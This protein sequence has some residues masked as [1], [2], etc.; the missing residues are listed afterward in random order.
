MR[1]IFIPLTSRSGSRLWLNPRFVATMYGK[2]EFTC[3][4]IIGERTAIEVQ[5]SP[6]RIIEIIL[7]LDE[8]ET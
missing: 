1:Q 5:E 2:S 4:W 7:E 6:D 8:E 3:L